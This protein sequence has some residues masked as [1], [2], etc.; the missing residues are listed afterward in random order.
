MG[1]SSRSSGDTTTADHPFVIEKPAI[2]FLNLQG[3]SGTPLMDKDSR[4]LSPLF[5]TSVTSTL[6]IPTC[7]VLFL[8]CDI[9]DNGQVGGT[10]HSLRDLFKHAGAYI[11][12]VASENDPDALIQAL[13]GNAGWFSNIVLVLDRKGG[14][15]PTFFR[16]L[17]EMMGTGTSMLM[18][19]VELVPQIPG[20]DH[21]DAPETVMLAEAG[22]VTFRHDG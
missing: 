17:F 20:Y 4:E 8:Y 14:K 19:W 18:A 21:K 13:E 3:D 1:R 2:G 6:E 16:R 12:V 10:T 5:N 7:G 15:C 11:A 9:N 22:H